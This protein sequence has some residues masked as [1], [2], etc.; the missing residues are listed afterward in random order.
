V[1]ATVIVL[2]LTPWA[3]QHQQGLL[4]FVHAQSKEPRQVQSLSIALA[5]LLI[6]LHECK[7]TI[8]DTRFASVLAWQTAVKE[9][10]KPFRLIYIGKVFLPKWQCNRK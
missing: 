2:A 4:P 5:F 8:R 1:P 6:K 3:A 9:P 10:Q 7:L